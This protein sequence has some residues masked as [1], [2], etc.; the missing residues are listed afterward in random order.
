[1][2]R[3]QGDTCL[4]SVPQSKKGDR[5]LLRL[6]PRPT[7]VLTGVLIQGILSTTGYGNVIYLTN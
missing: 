7:A 2:C 1:M 4:V 6:T 3:H 5:G